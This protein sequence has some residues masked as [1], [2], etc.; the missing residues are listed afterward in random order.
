MSMIYEDV[1]KQMCQDVGEEMF[2][3]LVE[4]FVADVTEKISSIEQQL[5][6]KDL[7]KLKITAHTLKSECA[8]YG[9][10][11]SSSIAKEL[12]LLCISNNDFNSVI[13]LCNSLIDSLKLTLEDIKTINIKS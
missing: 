5:K 10:L 2:D 8:Q 12:E 7:S 4:I 9:A 6:E 3:S 1:L 13:K 11:Q